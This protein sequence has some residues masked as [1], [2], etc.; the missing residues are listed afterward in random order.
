MPMGWK[1]IITSDD[2]HDFLGADNTNVVT[3]NPPNTHS[4]EAV[5]NNNFSSS[6]QDGALRSYFPTETGWKH[7]LCTRK[8]NTLDNYIPMFDP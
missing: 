1:R 6:T 3:I 2:I 5:F 4:F 8:N 7:I